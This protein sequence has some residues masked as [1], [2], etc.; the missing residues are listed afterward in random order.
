MLT[1][2]RPF[3]PSESAAAYD[4]D[5][6]RLI[7]EAVCFLYTLGPAT[8]EQIADLYFEHIDGHP[9]WPWCDW[10]SVRK[11]TS[12]ARRLDK[13]LQKVGTTKSSHGKTVGKY[14]YLEVVAA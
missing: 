9:S 4:P 13:R 14:G 8:D 2:A 7:R 5:Q 1:N 11:R 12:D 3:D 6:A 10:E